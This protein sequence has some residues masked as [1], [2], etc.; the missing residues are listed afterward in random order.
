[1]RGLYPDKSK[2]FC[3]RLPEKNWASGQTW[4]LVEGARGLEGG[5]ASV[6]RVGLSLDFFR[7]TTKLILSLFWNVKK[8]GY[9]CHCLARGHLLTIYKH[10]KN[11]PSGKL[12]WNEMTPV[13][14]KLLNKAKTFFCDSPTSQT[15]YLKSKECTSLHASRNLSRL[16]V[17]VQNGKVETPGVLGIIQFFFFFGSGNLDECYRVPFSS[18][19]F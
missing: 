17:K 8:K 10:V 15:G 9:F 2:L 14:E 7:A 19:L 16:S 5:R 11:L 13:T 18:L 4:W 3:K 6:P 1:M 12:L